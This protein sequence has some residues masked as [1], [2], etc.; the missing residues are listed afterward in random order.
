VNGHANGD[1]HPQESSPNEAPL[2]NENAEQEP[3]PANPETVGLIEGYP[4]ADSDNENN[5]SLGED[6][7]VPQEQRNAEE[8]QKEDGEKPAEQFQNDFIKKVSAIVMIQLIIS[9][10]LVL[11]VTVSG[12][13]ALSSAHWMFIFLLIALVILGLIRCKCLKAKMKNRKFGIAMI[14]IFHISFS[15]FIMY[16]A[17][18]SQAMLAALVS[19]I[20]AF[21]IAS[22]TFI[23]AVAKKDVVWWKLAIGWGVII[24][25]V[26]VICC[27]A[28]IDLVV[29]WILMGVL[30][31][32]ACT[33]YCWD[34]KR[35]ITGKN[36]VGNSP[37]KYD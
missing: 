10:F 36:K 35:L 1:V 29:F 26:T 30:V 37:F 12:G 11:I 25:I 33:A 5:P 23:L 4:G 17:A 21:L 18:V 3:E 34:I 7:A 2:S 15:L 16:V 24:L 9:F 19:M 31:A 14:A 22:S 27:I 32:A 13:D 28:V 20:L 8:E 6:P